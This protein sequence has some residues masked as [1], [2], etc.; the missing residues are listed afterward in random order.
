VSAKLTYYNSG[1]TGNYSTVSFLWSHLS[2]PV[3]LLTR[4]RPTTKNCLL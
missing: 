4:Y 1:L 2:A 3:R